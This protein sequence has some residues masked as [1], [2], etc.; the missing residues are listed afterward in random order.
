MCNISR[1]R[2]KLER[3][4]KFA[5][6]VLTPTEM[7]TYE[8][9]ELNDE[10]ALYPKATYI[11]KCW[12]VKEAFVKALGTGLTGDF[13]LHD[14]SYISPGNTRPTIKLS[15][16]AHFNKLMKNKTI[17]LSVSDEHTDVIAFVTIE[18]EL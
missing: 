14:I 7:L 6:K 1:V 3:N 9:I 16:R 17:H 18:E 11:A 4:R 2:E 13:Q 8:Q 5:D 10:Y 12:A 15:D